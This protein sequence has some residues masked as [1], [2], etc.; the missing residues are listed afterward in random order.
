VDH[1]GAWVWLACFDGNFGIR[2]GIQG[3]ISKF[4]LPSF[5]E[6]DTQNLKNI[7]IIKVCKIQGN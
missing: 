1:V 6:I 4:F 2:F 7:Q 5:P 3:F